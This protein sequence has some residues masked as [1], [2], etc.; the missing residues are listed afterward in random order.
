[1]QVILAQ[2]G[3]KRAVSPV[4][5]QPHTG[6]IKRLRPFWQWF[7]PRRDKQEFSIPVNVFR[8]QP[9]AGHA[10]HAYLLPGHPFHDVNPPLTSHKRGI[11]ETWRSGFQ[12]PPLAL[13]SRSRTCKPT[14]E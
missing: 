3:V 5:G 13:I 4:M 7:L 10:V 2:H 11:A 6:D 1:M 8:D 9:G 12:V 14:S